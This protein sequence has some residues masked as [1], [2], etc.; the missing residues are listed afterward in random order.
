MKRMILTAVFLVLLAAP[1]AWGADRIRIG[2]SSISGGYVGLW[3]ARDAGL[4]AREGLD[5][6]MI[7]IPSGSQLA[8]VAVAGEVDIASLNGSSA[9]AAALQG[10]DIKLIGSQVNKM[11]FSVH[12]RPGIKSI[13]EL[14]GKKIGVTRFGSS[15][16]IS[17]RY[18]LR[19]HNLQPEKDVAILQ[20]GA[21]TSIAAGLKGGSIDGGVVSP[22]TNFAL[23]KLGFKELISVTDLD[24]PFPS[25]SLA[26]QGGVIRSK[27]GVIDRFMRA[28]ARG[29]HRARTD[30]ELALKSMARYTKI[31][32]LF[33][34]QRAYDLFVGKVL[35]KAPYIEIAAMRTALDDLA[36]TTPAAK[37]AKAEQF[38]DLRFLDNLE[39]SG[40]LKEL[41][42]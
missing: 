4:F 22:P 2:Y 29:I 6:Q 21:M 28:Y 32:D 9:M 17:A 15:T 20:M 11:I 35:E 23:E 40:L 1:F 26:A 33:V 41:Y 24:I 38:I 12:V 30:K 39:K 36:R 31:E 27:P 34:L 16:D 5:E 8:Q 19:K 42:R 10:A 18:A 14:K 7:L 3:V 25:P 13:E 37:N